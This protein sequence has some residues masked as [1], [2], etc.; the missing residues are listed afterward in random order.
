MVLLI[1]TD[2]VLA[3]LEAVPAPRRKEL[4]LPTSLDLFGPIAHSQL[5]RL[6]KHLQ[7]DAEYNATERGISM[8]SP[9]ILSALLR[10]TTVYVPP[11]PKKPEP[12]PEYLA[13]K[14]RLQALAEKQAYQRLLNP[15][16]TPN[17][18]HA[19]PYAT[20]P[21]GT[22]YSEDALT[23]SLV[24]NIFLSTIITGF[25]V[26]WGLTSFG[27]PRILASMFSAMIGPAPGDGM[28]PRDAVGAS[29][30]VRVLLSFFAALSVA[31]A[32]S[33]L[34]AVY[35]GKVV[36]ARNKERKLKE[37]KVVIG[38]VEGEGDCDE[39]VIVGAEGEKEE[40]WGKGVNGGVRR[41]MRGKWEKEQD[42]NQ[43]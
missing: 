3:A 30:A 17:A 39:G 28:E 38:P 8:N 4:D 25:A 20:K 12:S 19:D 23:P 29:E 22:P 37:K 35:L 10:G 33:V 32:E 36:E 41:R 18:D 7:N 9:T 5:L 34:Y 6:S 14:A 2:R 1:A 21:D 27:M 43:D 13:E 26:Y 11:P 31:V 16:Y 42:Q 15:T 40:I 24:L